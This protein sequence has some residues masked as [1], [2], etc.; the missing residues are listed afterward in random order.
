MAL[1][2]TFVSANS[3]LYASHIAGAEITYK[4]LNGNKYQFF[5]KIYRDCNSCKFNNNGGGDNH[6]NCNEVPDLKII[7]ANGSNYSQQNFGQIDITRTKIK[8]LT[9][10]CYSTK[11][12]CTQGSNINIGYELHEFEGVFDFTTLL[13]QNKCNFE[14]S[15]DV[16]SRNLAI[17]PTYTEQK[18]YNYCHLNICNNT[19]NTSTEF[20]QVPTFLLFENQ[21]NSISLGVENKDGDSLSFKLKPA[22]VNRNQQ[23]TY[24]SPRNYEFPFYINCPGP[25][26]SNLFCSPNINK[27]PVEGF[28]FNSI[29][30]DL[31]F[32]PITNSQG[33]VIVIEC[34]EWKKDNNGKSYLAGVVR[35]DIFSEVV[36]FNN[37]LPK[38]V[39]LT[40]VYNLCKDEELDFQ[41]MTSDI[42]ISG[43]SPDS[44]TLEVIGDMNYIDIIRNFSN[45]APYNFY[46][47]KLKNN[48][49]SGTHYY[50]LV[51]K[52]N[53]CPINGISSKTIVINVLP[54]RQVNFTYDVQNCGE[55]TFKGS[56]PLNNK[57]KWTLL[58]A[59]DLLVKSGTGLNFKAQL[60]EGG[61]YKIKINCPSDDKY[62]ETEFEEI[63]NVKEFISPE[64]DLGSNYQVCKGV[65]F[66]IAPKYLK[67][68]DDYTVIFNNR[69]V[70]FPFD[71]LIN[72]STEFSFKI[73]Q[74]NGCSV[75]DKITIGINP[76]FNY[77][78]KDI[79]ICNNHVFPLSLS[80]YI[81]F[82]QND[83]SSISFETSNN[84]ISLA[85]INSKNTQL[86]IINKSI[87]TNAV[88]NFIMVDKNGCVYED[89]ISINSILPDKINIKL[90]ENICRNEKSFELP[91]NLNG[92]WYYTNTN[93]LV[94]NNVLI[95]DGNIDFVNLTY[96]ANDVCNQMLNFQINYSDTP[97]INTNIE[98]KLFVCEN[99]DNISLQGLPSNGK[100]YGL[101]VVNNLFIVSSGVGN[102]N[103]VSFKY[104]NN[105]G[106]TSIKN[107]EIIVE[108]LPI[109]EILTNKSNL[110]VGEPLILTANINPTH[111]GYWNTNGNGEFNNPNSNNVIYYPNFLDTKQPSIVF[112]Y[113]SQ[114]NGACGNVSKETSA[115]IKDGPKGQITTPLQTNICEPAPFKL[116]TNY[117]DI[118]KQLWYVND[119]LIEEYDYPFD[120]H[121]SLKAGVYKIK[122]V[123]SNDY[124]VAESSMDEILINPKPKGIIITNPLLKLNR[125]YPRIYIKDNN[126]NDI[127]RNWYVYDQWVSDQKDFYHNI[128]YQKDSVIIKLISKNEITG[129]IDSSKKLLIFTPINQLY[130]PDAFSPDSKGPDENNVFTV[131][132]PQMKN[133]YIMIYNRWGQKLYESNDMNKSWDGTEGG[134]LCKPDVYF[135][136]IKSTDLEGISRDYSGTVSIIR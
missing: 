89:K 70:E 116:S 130:I 61:K 115:Q 129:C 117:T 24:E 114:T 105:E 136:M 17:N 79:S 125:E 97:S 58:D 104:T 81:V 20:N 60:N 39:N 35:R 75:T 53:N 88:I 3:R 122:T 98:S 45:S 119:S 26:G 103:K 36:N 65:K 83:F 82:N 118:T 27:E 62:C 23:V 84:N 135:Y 50:T 10:V 37:N 111:N 31:Q 42:T 55:L 86:E 9:P 68:Y 14:I 2:L 69:K 71:T 44:V 29:S 64:F 107:H 76:S 101:N 1:A 12:K 33:G 121:I 66:K 90:P 95:N 128:Q 43:S 4:Y 85:E 56:K 8:D 74:K 123:V 109:I 96:K 102:N 126:N 134:V 49:P 28:Y 41:I 18:F 51:A 19:P 48:I 77:T 87:A 106:C 25:A 40:Q 34:E 63:I 80:E 113:T 94:E 47:I 5:L 16:S 110:C 67:T 100:W 11:S 112:S 46:S 133:Y 92:E 72:K 59:N 108:S 52:D 131:K 99:N 32:T 21:T 73:L 54:K 7:G 78:K 30:G 93:D 38:F 6:Q 15:I 91:L 22:L 132:G 120:A 13:N 57:T 127:T 124:C